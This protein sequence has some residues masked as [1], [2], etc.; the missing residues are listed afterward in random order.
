MDLVKYEL[1][2]MYIVLYSGALCVCV[3]HFWNNLILGWWFINLIRLKLMN[4]VSCVIRRLMLFCFCG[5]AGCKCYNL[6]YLVRMECPRCSRMIGSC[7]FCFTTFSSWKKRKCVGIKMKTCIRNKPYDHVFA[8][9]VL[10]STLQGEDE[11]V[12][13]AVKSARKA[14]DSWSKTPPHVRARYLYR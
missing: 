7:W 6:K 13:L 2:R 10:T 9:E 11:D 14:Y 3:W 1:L 8:G 12:E 5:D 4:T